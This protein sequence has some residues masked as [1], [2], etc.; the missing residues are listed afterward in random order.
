MI[1]YLDKAGIALAAICALGAAIASAAS[2]DKFT[3][4]STA[5]AVTATTETGSKEVLKIW[6]GQIE[7]N[8]AHLAGDFNG[9]EATEITMH[10][11]Y[12]ECTGEIGGS[13][14]AVT[15]DTTGCDFIFRTTTDANGDAPTIIEC[16]AGTAIKMTGPLG[17]TISI[18]AQSPTGGVSYVNGNDGV[19]DDVTIRTTDTHVVYE[20]SFACQLAGLTASA[21]DGVFEGA[22]TAKGYRY[23]T[24]NTLANHEG[25][26]YLGE[27][28]TGFRVD[29]P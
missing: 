2:A 15:A 10:P 11:T 27:I 26:E 23:T 22:V 7:C 24:K 6:S 4:D 28:Q 19:K 9:T 12:T 13:K 5:T 21:S 18:P 14:A 1:R 20:T 8:V 16:T 17:C 3:S 29:T 25:V